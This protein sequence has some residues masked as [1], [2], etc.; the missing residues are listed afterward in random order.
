[1]FV[2]HVLGKNS[3]LLY[4]REIIRINNLWLYFLPLRVKREIVFVLTFYSMNENC[5]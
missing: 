5:S 1:M 3:N 2:I 4:D